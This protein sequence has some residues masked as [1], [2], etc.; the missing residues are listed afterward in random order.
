MREDKTQQGPKNPYLLQHFHSEE[1]SATQRSDHGTRALLLSLGALM[2]FGLE[3]LFVG[4]DSGRSNSCLVIGLVGP[5]S[6]VALVTG[7]LAL[8]NQGRQQKHAL[9]G[10][11]ISM[12]FAIYWA[13][14]I[15]RIINL[16]ALMP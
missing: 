6:L 1:A 9:I 3:F 12:P 11:A 8:S 14:E 2:I 10:I 5:L 15:L 7:V 16:I 4:M 13:G